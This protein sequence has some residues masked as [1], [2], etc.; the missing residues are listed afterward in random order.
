[1]G[2]RGGNQGTLFG[3]RRGT[4]FSLCIG[5]VPRYCSL[6]AGGTDVTFVEEPVETGDHIVMTSV[7]GVGIEKLVDVQITCDQ[8]EF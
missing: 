3:N 1:M 4:Q 5:D 8:A 6:K 7:E 2:S